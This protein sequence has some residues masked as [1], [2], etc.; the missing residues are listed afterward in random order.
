MSHKKKD[1]EQ[2]EDELSD[3]LALAGM[4]LGF[5]DG[6][7][8]PAPADP[9]D[10]VLSQVPQASGSLAPAAAALGAPITEGALGDPQINGEHV[11]GKLG[12][13]DL[14]GGK[15]GKKIISAAE[16][17]EDPAAAGVAGLGHVEKVVN[18]HSDLIGKRAKAL[19]NEKPAEASEEEELSAEDHKELAE[20]LHNLAGNPAALIDELADAT[21]PLHAVAPQTAQSAQQTATRAVQF[22]SSKLNQ[23]APDP[24]GREY[25]S[26]STERA[27]FNR[28]LSVVEDPSIALHQVKAGMFLP[29][30]AETLQT[31]YPKLYD[32]MKQSVL[33]NL[34]PEMPYQKKLM[35]SQFLGTPLDSSLSSDR[36]RALQQSFVPPPPPGPVAPAKKPKK[37][38]S[39][40]NI[41][42][43]TSLKNDDND[44]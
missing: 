30:T 7:A 6:G 36:I 9:V 1:E 21:L 4:V 17:A 41:S 3:D 15:L 22:L 26:S 25:E 14:L 38:L 33:E 42:E 18:D 35:V 28:Y 11:L 19:F 12:L 24:M 5:S 16:E 34:D 2:D 32:K 43:R 37:S 13:R 8:V 39:K 23:P 20:R 40:L 44:L 10:Q 31:V 29:E 27:K